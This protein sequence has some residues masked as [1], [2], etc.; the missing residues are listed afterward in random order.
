MLS[1][2]KIGCSSTNTKYGKRLDTAVIELN[3]KAN[4]SGL[5]TSN[6]FKSA[7]VQVC[8]DQFKKKM[9]GKKMLIVNAG[10]AN[11]ATGE[12]GVEDTIK[13]INNIS[14]LSGIEFNQIL[15]FSTGVVGELLDMESLVPAFKD[16]I[17]NLSKNTW[18][19]FAKAI[20][21]TD[22]HHKMV[23][24]EVKIGSKKFKI[25]GIAKGVGMIEPN[26]ATTLSYV[27]TD[28]K[29]PTIKLK[30]LHKKACDNS[31]NVISI[32]GDQSPSDSTIL[33]ATGSVD[34]DIKRYE[35]KIERELLTV[36]KKL[37]E[38]LV[39][40]GEGATKLIRINVKGLSSF[41]DCKKVA[42]KIANSSLVKTAAYGED[43][44]WGRIISAAGNANVDEFDM[45]NLNLKIGKHLVLFKGNLSKSYS[46]S[47]GKREF[48]KKI[49][50]LDITL[51]KSK[52]SA[53]IMTSDLTPDYISINSDYRS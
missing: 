38:K 26:M 42:L 18:S 34:I 13:L 32:D 2:I 36:F 23:K 20:M 1:D 47:K 48:R 30:K 27:F 3:T 33:V 39:L 7:P 31:F 46:E 5:F 12:K 49:I 19:D 16:C 43:P 53:L 21:T 9:H 50:Q 40:D 10:N 25:I 44:N 22:T 4:I 11:A 37:S 29:I 51:G 28:L 24:H 41:D 17:K 6:K 8:L 45:N 14:N 52:N 15:P 35:Q